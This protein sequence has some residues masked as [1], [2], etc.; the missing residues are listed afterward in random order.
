MR[1][2]ALFEMMGE[3][4]K[5]QCQLNHFFKYSR[6]F[7]NKI[8]MQFS[9]LCASSYLLLFNFQIL[10]STFMS[11]NSYL[12]KRRCVMTLW[13]YFLLELFVCRKLTFSNAL[14]KLFSLSFAAVTSMMCCLIQISYRQWL[15]SMWCAVR[16]HFRHYSSLCNAF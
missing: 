13:G 3:K 11:F 2:I 9:K 7:C 10:S 5:A 8:N 12:L 4:K 15:F 14:Q 16:C 1:Y 6:K